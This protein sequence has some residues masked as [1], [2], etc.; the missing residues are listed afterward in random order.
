MLYDIVTPF[1]PLLFACNMQKKCIVDLTHPLPLGAFKPK[2]RHTDIRA[3]TDIDTYAHIATITVNRCNI[4]TFHGVPKVVFNIHTNATIISII[5]FMTN[6][7][8][9]RPDTYFGQNLHV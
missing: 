8:H 4:S 3:H 9:S 6:L 7:L 5:T 1:P 2:G